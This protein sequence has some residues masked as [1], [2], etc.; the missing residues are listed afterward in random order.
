M[1]R[2]DLY[3]PV[4]KAL[5]YADA[6]VLID[7]GNCPG[8]PGA[9]DR[10]LRAL[11]EMLVLHEIH[12]RVEDHVVIPALE[13]KRLGSAARLVNAHREHEDSIS[14]M[15]TQIAVVERDPTR[16]ALHR[17]YLEVT[18]F[19]GDAN[20]HMYEEETLAQP[21]FEE[22]YSQPELAQIASRARDSVTP[23]EHQLFAGY[24]LPS[25]S[26]ADRQGG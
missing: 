16:D 3:A 7:L 8:D 9:I 15:R 21:L 12:Q 1:T 11:R 20:L 26:H 4:H 18:R 24:F 23:A 14:R 6:R 25:M 19:V 2:V 10:A 22:V 17:L 13:A 5:R